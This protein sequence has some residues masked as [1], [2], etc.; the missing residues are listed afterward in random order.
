M[1]DNRVSVPPFTPMM[2]LAE[3]WAKGMG[4]GTM[5]GEFSTPEGTRQPL[6]V[7][8]HGGNRVFVRQDRDCLTVFVIVEM[9]QDAID[10]VAKLSP[11]LQRRLYAAFRLQ[12]MMHGRTGFA[13]APTGAKH[14]RE[15]R[16]VVIEQVVRIEK[17]DTSTYNRYADAIQEVVTSM[18]RA[19][20]V[21][22][23]LLSDGSG[24]AGTAGVRRPPPNPMY[25]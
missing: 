13:T 3:E 8:D 10:K 19:F 16:R 9:E 11:D 25:Q 1:D 5:R 4:K 2:E 15:I 24:G 20:S 12:L 7:V 18:V 23:H 17:N 6:L 21:F 14:L 22:G